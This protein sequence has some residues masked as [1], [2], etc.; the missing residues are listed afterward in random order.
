MQEG[1]SIIDPFLQQPLPVLG[2]FAAQEH[3]LFSIPENSEKHGDF[4]QKHLLLI[5]MQ[6]LGHSLEPLEAHRSLMDY[7][8]D[9]L[10]ALNLRNHLQQQFSIA[11][12]LSYLLSGPSFQAL[13]ERIQSEISLLKDTSL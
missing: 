5:L 12:P 9:S 6:V 3:P 13:T 2:L 1:F 10:L 7:G 8:L 11:L 4:L